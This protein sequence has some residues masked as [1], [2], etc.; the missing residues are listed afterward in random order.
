M[1][2]KGSVDNGD[3]KQQPEIEEMIAEKVEV[4]KPEPSKSSSNTLLIFGLIIA[5]ILSY[6]WVE[7]QDEIKNT[8]FPND[9]IINVFETVEEN[10]S[11]PKVEAKIK[12]KPKQKYEKP[13]PKIKVKIKTKIEP[14]NEAKESIADI[15]PMI[16]AMVDDE[17]IS[18][19]I[20]EQK[21]L[22]PTQQDDVLLS[23][24]EQLKQEKNK[25]AV[26]LDATR[27]NYELSNL[28]IHFLE[29]EKNIYANEN[30]EKLLALLMNND[31]LPDEVRFALQPLNEL[32]KIH[33][34][35]SSELKQEMTESIKNYMKRE[36]SQSDVDIA[37]K[38][39]VVAR[40]GSIVSV[41]KIG[42]TST[43]DDDE[44]IIARAEANVAAGENNKVIEEL[45]GLSEEAEGY[46]RDL[47]ELI[48]SN[49][50]IKNSLEKAGQSFMFIQ[51]KN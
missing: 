18:E 47:V 17:L 43:G 30:G 4:K 49:N 1:S 42:S 22:V 44:A 37:F 34:A 50:I 2:K 10:I 15:I 46:F 26:E 21:D 32:D 48:N 23:E 24:I 27:K 51:V 7:F 12:A 36:D 3:T 11:T 6:A 9:E 16:D 33:L 20:E 38:D 5:V 14:N 39:K 19:P 29:L 8:L 25:L 35:Q 40:L 45:S 28:H 13:E 41:R 31:D